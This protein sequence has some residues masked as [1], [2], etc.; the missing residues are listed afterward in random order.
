[1]KTALFI[2][3]FSYYLFG[4]CE[5]G[6]IN[7]NDSDESKISKMKSPVILIGKDVIQSGLNAH[8]WITIKDSSG[9]I[10]TLDGRL[11]ATFQPYNIGDTIK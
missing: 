3:F 6:T 2:L 8:H 7:Q 10:T 9:I 11:G 4:C 1:M 5:G